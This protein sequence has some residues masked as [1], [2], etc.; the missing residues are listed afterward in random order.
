MFSYNPDPNFTKE[1]MPFSS[2]IDFFSSSSSPFLPFSPG[3]AFNQDSSFHDLLFTQ[4]GGETHS[5]LTPPTAPQPI[6][7]TAPPP[8]K[9]TTVV[10]KRATGKDRHS[11]IVTAQGPRVRRMR[12]NLEVAP[13]FFDIQDMLGYDKAS[14]TVQWL[15]KEAKDSIEKLKAATRPE[16]DHSLSPKSTEAS[17]SELEWEEISA[18]S[19]YKGKSSASQQEN[20]STPKAKRVGRRPSRRVVYPSSLG[21]ESRDK[22]RERARERTEKKKKSSNMLTDEIRGDSSSKWNQLFSNSAPFEG[23]D[24]E[25]GSHDV[26]SSLDFVAEVEEQCSPSTNQAKQLSNGGEVDE[27]LVSIL[28]YNNTLCPETTNLFPAEQWASQFPSIVD[29]PIQAPLW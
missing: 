11:K 24:E 9:N 5:P 23:I 18:V 15:M 13:Q 25:S 20:I 1:S 3:L 19:D 14:K 8:K 26:K 21:R 16:V 27:F 22:A 29:V 10:R 6:K 17:T 4:L 28:D 2:H 12:L 7:E